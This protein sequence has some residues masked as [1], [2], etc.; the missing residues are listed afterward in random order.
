M[1]DYVNNSG[2]YIRTVP[3]AGIH[4]TIHHCRY[5]FQLETDLRE[6]VLLDVEADLGEAV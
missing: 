1:I 2:Q 4:L 6:A 5:Y 3:R